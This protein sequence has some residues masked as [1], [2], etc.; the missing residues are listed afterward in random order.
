[1]EIV[2]D[3]LHVW[4]NILVKVI[5]LSNLHCNL[6]FEH[7]P[8]SV[9]AFSELSRSFIQ[10]NA[11]IEALSQFPTPKQVL[12]DVI[13]SATNSNLRQ[14][15]RYETRRVKDSSQTMLHLK[16]PQEFSVIGV[17]RRKADS[18]RMAAALACSHLMVTNFI[19]FFCFLWAGDAGGVVK[20]EGVRERITH[21]YLTEI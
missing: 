20:V 10:D 6:Q 16:W 7:F 15:L 18:E 17:G 11:S 9:F 8:F 5:L 3:H 14:F 21:L 4:C 1:M 13:T 19:L 12:N 2:Q